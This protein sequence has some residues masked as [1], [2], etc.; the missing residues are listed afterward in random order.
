MKSASILVASPRVFPHSVRVAFQIFIQNFTPLSMF[1]N[2]PVPLET[3]PSR[4]L[5]F[6]FPSF[7]TK[8]S[9]ALSRARRAAA[10]LDDFGIAPFLASDAEREGRGGRPQRR[11]RS[12]KPSLAPLPTRADLCVRLPL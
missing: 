12:I 8:K 1:K 4:R 5:F 7:W 6:A 3:K 10:R 11:W 2:F 9:V